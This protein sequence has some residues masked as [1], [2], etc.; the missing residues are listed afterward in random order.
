MNTMSSRGF[1]F[2]QFHIEHDRC[3]MKV[4]TDGILLGAWAPLAGAQRIL[5]VGTG[6]G[7]IAL[8]LAQ[9][10]QPAVN[11]VGLELDK[12][13]A[14]QAAENVAASPWA[15]RVDIV[16][17]QVQDYT[18]VARFDLLVSNPPY[19]TQGLALPKTRSQARYNN[20]LSLAEL[21]AHAR[22]LL[23]PAGRLALVLPVQ[24][25]FEAKVQAAEQDFYLHTQ[26]AVLTKQGKMPT[27]FLLLFTSSKCCTIYN[28]LIINTK[29]SGLSSDY[30]SL[31]SP[32]YLKM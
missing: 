5:D 26:T 15:Q 23:T 13:A 11:V 2:K 21:F 10:S 4:G 30:V 17:E 7:L 19:F 14:E 22:R 18:P 25:H 16:P 1:T 28:E 8:M 31:V 9:R 27:R 12:T 20:S 6:S 32:F 24:A 29:D 3:A